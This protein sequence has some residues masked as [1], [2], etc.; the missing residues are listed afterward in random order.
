V[1][2]GGAGKPL[3][4][5]TIEDAIAYRAFLRDPAPKAQWGKHKRTDADWGPFAGARNPRSIADERPALCAS[6]PE[7]S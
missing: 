7:I 6:Y 3:S 4:S 5:L 1:D 2:H